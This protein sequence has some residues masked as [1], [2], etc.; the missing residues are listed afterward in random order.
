[1]KK[2][3]EIRKNGN[4]DLI[5]E[6]L[7]HELHKISN[8]AEIYSNFNS[9]EIRS[10]IDFST[11]DNSTQIDGSNGEYM[12]A[13]T[14]DEYNMMIRHPSIG[15][16]AHHANSSVNITHADF[17]WNL[18]ENCNADHNSPI[19]SLLATDDNR[20]NKILKKS[21]TD[22]SRIVCIE[23]QTAG[24]KD[25]DIS[26]SISKSSTKD[27]TSSERDRFQEALSIRNDYSD[28]LGLSDSSEEDPYAAS[29]D[30]DTDY[31]PSSNSNSSIETSNGNENDS[32]SSNNCRKMCT[33]N[34]VRDKI[35]RRQL[36]EDEQTEKK[37]R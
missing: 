20:H 4:I 17:S 29:E 31:V 3:C 27:N 19:N 26:R 33:R 21:L 30:G 2:F 15:N 9:L 28:P 14:V 22:S 13:L 8:E 1:M 12:P 10:N 37:T 11:I 16:N 7:G 24:S 25:V 34:C 23:S 5:S 6:P 32:I 36:N 35:R 18:Y